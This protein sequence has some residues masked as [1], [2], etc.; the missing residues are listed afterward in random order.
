MV[1]KT[2]GEIGNLTKEIHIMFLW[3]IVEKKHFENKPQMLHIWYLYLHV[4]Q[5][6]QM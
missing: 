4:P 2:F 1:S 5:I 6:K 3:N